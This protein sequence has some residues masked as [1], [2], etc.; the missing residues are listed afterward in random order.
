MPTKK[1]GNDNDDGFTWDPLEAL[2]D[3]VTGD[4]FSIFDEPVKAVEKAAG[5]A[6]DR[7]AESGAGKASKSSGS[8]ESNPVATVE[9]LPAPAKKGKASGKPEQTE[10]GK[11]DNGGKEGDGDGGKP[12]AT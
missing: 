8:T 10:G 12:P 2:A 6:D 4:A 5:V 9:P 7:G 11:P 3:I 1:E